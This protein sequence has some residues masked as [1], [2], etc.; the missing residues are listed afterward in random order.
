MNDQAALA[1][2]DIL[3][4]AGDSTQ[5]VLNQPAHGFGVIA[6]ID[7]EKVID[8]ANVGLAVVSVLS[9]VG[10]PPAR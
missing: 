6:E 4:R 9:P 8:P 5:A 3:S 7:L 10:S 2:V 1:D